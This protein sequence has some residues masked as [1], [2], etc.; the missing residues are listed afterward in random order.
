MGAPTEGFMGAV[1][2]ELNTKNEAREAAVEE[3][4]VAPEQGAGERYPSV[5]EEEEPEPEPKAKAAK[6]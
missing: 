3:Q 4:H 1:E 6:K 5:V 2:E